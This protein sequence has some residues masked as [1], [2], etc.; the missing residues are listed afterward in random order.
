[1]LFSDAKP[2]AYVTDGESLYRVVRTLVGGSALAP[3]ETVVLE[4]A[5]TGKTVDR[6]GD[7]IGGLGW[8]VVVPADPREPIAA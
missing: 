8:R 7:E 5:L 1:M 3:R 2:E 4:D 6:S